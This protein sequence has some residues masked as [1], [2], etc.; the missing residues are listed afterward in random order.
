MLEDYVDRSKY[1]ENCPLAV[2][3]GCQG[4]G[5]GGGGDDASHFR[6]IQITNNRLFQDNCTVILQGISIR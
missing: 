1:G 2:N 6:I 3:I 4:N 5:E